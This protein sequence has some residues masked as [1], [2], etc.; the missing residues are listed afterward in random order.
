MLLMQVDLLFK[1]KEVEGNITRTTIQEYIPVTLIC[2]YFVQYLGYKKSLVSQLL[3]FG[4]IFFSSSFKLIV[5]LGST[6]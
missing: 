4:Y 5:F 3:G 2:G 6:L 1:F